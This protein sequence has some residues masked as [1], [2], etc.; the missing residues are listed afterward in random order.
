MGLIMGKVSKM[1]KVDPIS[2]NISQKESYFFLSHKE[3]VLKLPDK[4]ELLKLSFPHFSSYY[5]SF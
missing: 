1:V 3:E 2:L 5:S 4:D